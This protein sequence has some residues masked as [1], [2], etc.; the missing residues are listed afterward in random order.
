MHK[1]TSDLP[2]IIFGMGNDLMTQCYYEECS[3]AFKEWAFAEHH[4]QYILFGWFTG[5]I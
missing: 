3:N 4:P 5:H 1:K 2:M